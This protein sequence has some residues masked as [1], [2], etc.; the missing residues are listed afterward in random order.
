MG[1]NKGP[2]DKNLIRNL[3]FRAVRSNT[4]QHPIFLLHKAV[5][6]LHFS[7]AKWSILCFLLL[8][9]QKHPGGDTTRGRKRKTQIN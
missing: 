4:V 5:N 7:P 2:S 9:F 1:Q 8:K 3:L 6:S